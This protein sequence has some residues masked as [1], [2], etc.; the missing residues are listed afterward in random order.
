MDNAPTTTDVALPDGA[1]SVTE[2][3]TLAAT[4]D[5]NE[6]VL[7]LIYSNKDGIYVRENGA[8]TPV[9]LD[10]DQPTIDDQEWFDVKLDFIPVYDNL[11]ETSDSIARDE[12]VPYAAAQPQAS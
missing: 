5:D 11:S 10:I 12:V 6:N 2:G 4:V 8:W 7:E 9:D 1:T 3:N